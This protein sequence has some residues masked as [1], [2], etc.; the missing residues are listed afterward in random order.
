M[1]KLLS[2]TMLLWE[3]P[4]CHLA[5]NQLSLAIWVSSSLTLTPSL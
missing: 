3:K 5:E 2:E 1:Y 4:V